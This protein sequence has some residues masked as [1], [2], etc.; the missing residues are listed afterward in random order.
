MEAV[1]ALIAVVVLVLLARS[2]RLAWRHRHISRRVWRAV[3]PQHVAGSVGLLAVVLATL[4]SLLAFVP[5]AWIGLGS[6]VGLTGNAVFAPLEGVALAGGDEASGLAR[7]PLWTVGTAMG[8]LVLLVALL[9][10]LAFVEERIFR[11]GLEQASLPRE[12]WS[13]LRFG[14]LH[15]IMLIP[16]GAALAIAVA[17]FIYGR[18][19]RR[20]YARS[21]QRAAER[22]RAAKRRRA[23]EREQADPVPA[24]AAW[25]A[26]AP[27]GPTVGQS[28]AE[29]V[30]AATVW[31]T[32]FNTLVVVLVGVALLL[33]WA[34]PA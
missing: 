31:H 18:I 2:A 26:P 21:R 22:Q 25:P 28:R 16:L 30:L 33:E 1:R 14:L 8:F 4:A 6:L 13:A 7:P 5:G 17:G 10:W 11:E 3:R 24:G 9:P 34:L 12:L 23:A 32:T 29:A 20:A 27:V 19:Y 15:L